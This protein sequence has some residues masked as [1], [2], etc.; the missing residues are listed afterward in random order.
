[1]S[2]KV[3]RTPWRGIVDIP[4]S[5]SVAHRELIARELRSIN[6]GHDLPDQ[7]AFLSK[8]KCDDVRAT[9]Q[10][11]RAIAAAYRD[12]S[13]SVVTVDCGA[14]GTT[15]RLLM[16]IAGALG[17]HT[18]FMMEEG[19]AVRPQDRLISILSGHGCDVCKNS[20]D[21]SEGRPYIEVSGHLQAGDYPVPGNISSQYISGLMFALPLIGGS[22]TITVTG[23]IESM[24]Y[25]DLTVDTQRS[26]GVDIRSDRYTSA[27]EGNAAE[28]IRTVFS[29]SR[30]E[31]ESIG[32]SESIDRYDGDWSSASYF[33]AAM[34][35]SG[36]SSVLVRG[37]RDDSFQGD[38]NI[39]PLLS[40]FD[41]EKSSNVQERVIDLSDVPDL[42]PILSVVAAGSKGITRFTGAKRLHYKESDRVV[43][44][45]SLI[46]SI[47]GK[48]EICGEN[49]YLV[50]GYAGEEQTAG[51][52]ADRFLPGGTV[53][54]F[55]DHR[56]AMAAAVAS[57]ICEDGP[58]I[59]D[60]GC[61]SKSYPGFF[62]VIEG[63]G[64][65]LVRS[66]G[67][68]VTAAD[69]EPASD[70]EKSHDGNSRC[71]VID[72]HTHIF[73]DTLA[74]IAFPKLKVDAE[75]F[76][77]P[78]HNMTRSALLKCMDDY[79]VDMSVVLPVIT[80]RKQVEPVNIW[81]LSQA[82]ERI[83]P[84]G[85]IY[86]DSDDWKEQIDYVCSLGLR[87]L[88]FHA[89]Y[90]EFVLDEPRMLR[91][92]DYALS[93]GLI[94]IHHSGFDPAY[95]EPYRSSPKRYAHMVDELKGGVI[96]AAHLGGSRQWDDVERY[97]VGKN[98]YLDTS[99]GLQYY[100]NEQFMRIVR[101]HGADRILF[102]T[103][104]PW[105]GADRELSILRGLPLTDEEREKILHLNAERLLHI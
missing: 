44:S 68:T 39:I 81:A 11:I 48:T 61:V 50:Y 25:I 13:E 7:T 91:I 27:A 102:A 86:P 53:D 28:D 64:A 30:A 17:V 78:V 79:G 88:K 54:S 101:G 65:R 49:E 4:M 76:Y 3:L 5:K 93:K 85:G 43:S 99:M 57:F 74:A 34:K 20:P 104:S 100:P 40:L 82:S 14:S 87:G 60:E 18:R 31:T 67:D 19:L 29:F 35:L 38:R 97:L 92:Y 45:C 95:P 98:I 32:Q 2:I 103:D 75:A 90:Q 80:K 15:L 42:A 36:Q 96:V 46:N 23:T 1:M 26:C 63:L 10:A 71:R 33:F 8:N 12:N 22:S 73:N 9:A 58:V 21:G 77:T 55:N 89:E 16:P 83:M 56:I 105:T 41:D 94:L 37:L 52:R 6:S 70:D 59:R 66:S 51:C 62:E 47:G 24:P 69:R 72:F 84:F